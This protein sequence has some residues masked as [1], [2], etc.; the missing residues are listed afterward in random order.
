MRDTL[1]GV[2]IEIPI[3]SSG[4]GTRIPFEFDD[5]TPVIEGAIAS[6]P[7]TFSIDTGSRSTLD[8]FA[9]FVAANNLESVLEPRFGALTGWG[10]GGGVRSKVAPATTLRL[11]GLE[12]PGVVVAIDMQEKG[13]FADRYTGG[14]IGGGVLKRFTVTFDYANK[15][16]ILEPNADFAEPEPYDRSGM[17]IQRKGGSVD[18]LDVVP[19]GAADDAG[20]GVGARIVSIDGVPVSELDLPEIR[21]RFRK[22][23]PGTIFELSV[24]SDDDRATV[25]LVLK[26]L[27]AG[28]VEAG[29]P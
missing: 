24:D 8:L 21:E 9:P 3:P 1:D 11:G 6:I 13:A 15:L 7:T 26:D 27:L 23:P 18:V 22:R 28:D 12:I 17:S 10:V 16:M 25:L 29:T 20:I 5:R 14:N 4:G 19:G 2:E